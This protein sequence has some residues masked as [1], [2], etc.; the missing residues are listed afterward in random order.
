[1]PKTGFKTVTVT[2]ELYHQIQQRSK[3]EK[4]SASSFV[5]EAL[6]ILLYVEDKF[7]NY[8]PFLELISLHNAEVIVRDQKKNRIVGVRAKNSNGG[9]VS[10]YCDTDDTDYCPHTAFAAALPQVRNAIRH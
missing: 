8:V 4:K 2:T 5:S 1:M 7:S 10:F 6:K 9:R 3:K